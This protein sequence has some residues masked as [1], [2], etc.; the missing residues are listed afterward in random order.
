[1]STHNAVILDLGSKLAAREAIEPENISAIARLDI[2]S[3]TFRSLA[4]ILSRYT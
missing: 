3:A 1:M 2:K 4:R